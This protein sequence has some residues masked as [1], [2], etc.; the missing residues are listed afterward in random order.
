MLFF[1]LYK[2]AEIIEHNNL[3]ILLLLVDTENTGLKMHR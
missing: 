3:N 2:L 1:E